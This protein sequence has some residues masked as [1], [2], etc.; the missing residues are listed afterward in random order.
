MQN[1][2]TQLVVILAVIDDWGFNDVSYHNRLNANDLHMPAIDYLASTG[3]ILENHYVN[4]ACSPTRSSLLTS[5]YQ[6]HT[7]LQHGIIQNSQKSCLP[8]KFGTMADAFKS[9]GYRTAMVGKW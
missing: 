5:R 4:M 8:P 7:G 6:I 3:V 9:G 2:S 1:A